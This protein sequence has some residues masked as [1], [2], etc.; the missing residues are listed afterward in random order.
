MRFS[1][2]EGRQMKNRRVFNRTYLTIALVVLGVSVPCPLSPV[3]CPIAGAEEFKAAYVNIGKLFDG[4]ERT[5]ASEAVLEKKGKQKEAELEGRVNELKK[6]REGLELLNNQARESKMR[7]IEAKADKLK[8]FQTNTAGDLRKERDA[9]AQEI[10][11]E[12]QSAV[13]DYA[14]TNGY[15]LIL[16]ERSVLYGLPALDVSDEVLA[17]LNSRY[18][19]KH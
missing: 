7:E 16:D 5:K 8:R 15:T 3:P 4:Y 19:A 18:G 14:K 6:S 13:A 11:K 9:I 10:L 12:I 1:K 17:L 2:G